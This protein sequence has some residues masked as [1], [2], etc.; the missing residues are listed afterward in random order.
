MEWHINDLSLAGQY[1]NPLD[2]RSALEPLLKLRHRSPVFAARLYCS[3]SFSKRQCTPSHTVQHAVLALKDKLYTTLVLTWL[4]KSGPFWD[5][6]RVFDEDDL[7]Y[8]EEA[9]VTNE[10]LGEASR[11]RIRFV[12]AGVF[13]F[14]D[15]VG[16]F[17]KTPLVVQHGLREEPLPDVEVPNWWSISELAITAS[18]NPQSW[19]EMLVSAQIRF[20]RLKLSESILGNLQSAPFHAGI[21]D[22][23]YQR[24][25]VL[26]AIATETTD[27]NGTLS[28]RG[29]RMYQDHFVGEKAQFSPEK[30]RREGDLTF[31]DP[32]DSTRQL[33][34]PWHAKVRLGQY[35]IHFEWPR[36]KRSER[37]QD[38][39]HRG[40]KS[41][42]GS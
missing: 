16:R 32:D 42:N 7:F 17:A 5:D 23:I 1:A 18:G 11:R 26:E 31:P 35:R 4:S 27:M 12:E 21:V 39:V 6:E 34:C 29:M 15:S 10:G 25:S 41:Q 9:D 8:F 37:D 33:Y 2:F 38:C 30:P 36:P 14:L 13:S 19:S 40:P 22:L 3:R 28:E 20:G 24:L